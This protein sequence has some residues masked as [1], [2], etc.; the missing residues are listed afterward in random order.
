MNI[1]PINEIISTFNFALPFVGYQLITT[2]FL[3][4]ATLVD[5]DGDASSLSQV[6]TVPYRAFVLGVAI[7]T[8]LLNTKSENVINPRTKLFLFFWFLLL[9]RIFYD[10]QIRSDIVANLS[11]KRQTWVYILFICLLPTIA[12]MKS[13]RAIDLDLAFKLIFG[14][15]VLLIPISYINN[16]ILFSSE[17]VGR[18]SGNIALNTISFGH[19]GTSLFLISLFTFNKNK[20]LLYRLLCIT[21]MFFGCFIMMRAASRGPLFSLIV[22]TLFYVVSKRNSFIRSIFFLLSA[23]LVFLLFGSF[24]SDFIT[25]YSPMMLRRMYLEDM[26]G[27]IRKNLYQI[28]WSLFE[29]NPI[30]GY[31]FA[32]FDVKGSFIYSHNIVLDAF[33]GLGLFGGLLF[34][35]L[36]L[37]VFYGSYKLI[38]L[39]TTIGWIALLCVHQVIAHMFSG[40][41]YSSDL[42]NITI[43]SVLY[44]SSNSNYKK[45]II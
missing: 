13:V 25:T 6:V 45:F 20:Q 35:S 9:I 40:A 3:P 4:N 26:S 21:L 18:L 8:L 30:L 23:L 28:A 16:S 22:C 31:S 11:E 36:L 14:G 42:L 24:I 41:F 29:N 15:F 12:V 38:H 19:Y 39:N 32:V 44:Y 43:V 17:D 7:V 37:V 27:E 33:M 2:L 5:I 10:L 1:K 34:V